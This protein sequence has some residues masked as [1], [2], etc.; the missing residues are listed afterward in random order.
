MTQ[1]TQAHTSAHG[2]LTKTKKSGVSTSGVKLTQECEVLNLFLYGNL[3]QAG[4]GV[5]VL[6]GL[7]NR[8][9][10]ILEGVDVCATCGN[11]YP[12]DIVSPD[13]ECNN[14]EKKR[15]ATKAKD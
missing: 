7:N 14:C 5:S 12:S 9:K 8:V 6:R 1:V 13:G 11:I 2:T 4:I 3:R 10:I 15:T